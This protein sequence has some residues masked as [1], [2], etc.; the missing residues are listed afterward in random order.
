MLAGIPAPVA[1]LLAAALWGLLGILG[2]GAQL[3]GVS[4]LEVAFWRA[5]LGGAAF[6]LA[7]ARAR[8]A[9][10]RGRDL[11]VTLLF[12]LVGVSAFYAAYQLAVFH[13]GASLAAVLLYTAP[14]FVALAGVLL[15]RDRV[16]PAG[17]GAVGLTVGGVA[18]VSLG[19]GGAVSVSAPALL[20]GLGAGLCYSLYY[21]YGR[22][23][24]SR[25]R[26]DV[27]YAVAMPAGALALLPLV[28]FAPKS[29]LAWAYLLAIALLCTYAAY[30]LYA[31]GLAGMHP[32]R[33]SILA[34]V[35]PLVAAA[36]AA[37]LLAERLAPLSYLGG[38]LVVTAAVL[39]A[40]LGR[41]G[42]RVLHS[43]ERT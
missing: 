32:T 1:I 3:E 2:R 26:A 4:P 38:A 24:F 21:L 15:F 34:S 13:G 35:E 27:L 10:P 16:G 33:A 17:W 25:Y 29:V 28:G 39:P 9:P 8:A 37:A 36:L 20:W 14:A 12:G 22:V 5:A 7:A 18:L 11:L 42:G 23:Y 41:R 31:R 30:A 40:L 19:G 6:A 43:S